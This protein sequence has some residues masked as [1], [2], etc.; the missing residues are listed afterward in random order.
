MSDQLDLHSLALASIAHRCTRETDAF[1]HRQPHDPTYC[2]ELFRRAIVESCQPAWD[3]IYAQYQPLVA[4]WVERHPAFVLTGEEPQFFVNRAFE[5]MWVALDASKFPRF[6]NLKSLLRYLQMCVHSTI[7]DQSRKAEQAVADERIESLSDRSATE[8]GLRH[9][10][11]ALAGVYRQEFWEQISARLNDER[12]RQVV[13][14]SFALGLKPSELQARYRDT[15]GDVREVYR[16]KE[17]VL[18]RLR[19]DA[20]L[21][22]IL[23]SYA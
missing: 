15:F 18:A 17:N 13:Y 5:K 21:A 19:R 10:D 14:G 20:E 22:E 1:F 6:P 8:D 2:Y 4:G 11:P 7:V 9:D 3:V 16:V 23:G 12:E